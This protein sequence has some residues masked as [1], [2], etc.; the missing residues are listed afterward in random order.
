MKLAYGLYHYT[1]LKKAVDTFGPAVGYLTQA[2]DRLATDKIPSHALNYL[3]EA[4]KA[5]VAYIPG[6]GFLVD[7]TFDRLDETVDAHA[8]EANAIIGQAYTDIVQIVQQGGNR[9]ETFSVLEILS[10][11]RRLVKELGAL[12]LKAGQPLAERLELDKKMAAVSASASS[13]VET[14]KAKS[15]EWKQ[16]VDQATAKVMSFPNYHRLTIH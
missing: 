1:G 8:E 6:A 14:V 4:A 15:P 5:Y 9:H 10:V 11:C 12:G 7:R 13:L 2:R 16:S 3:R